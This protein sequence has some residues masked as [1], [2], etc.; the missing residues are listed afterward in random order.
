MAQGNGEFVRKNKKLKAVDGHFMILNPNDGWEYLNERNNYIDVLSFG[1][2]DKIIKGCKF[3]LC[4]TKEKSLDSPLGEIS[5]NS[6]FLESS[7]NAEH[8]ASGQLLKRIYKLSG[9]NEYKFTCPNELTIELLYS[10]YKEQVL[11]YKIIENI[12]AIK[13]STRIET[14]KRLLVAYEYIHDNIREQICIEQLSAVSSLSKFHLYDSFKKAFGKTP[15]QY[16]NRL[17]VSKA[18]EYIKK[19]SNSISEVSDLLGYNDLSVFSKVFK[20]VYGH[21]PSHYIN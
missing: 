12:D 18:K 11:G 7:L 3:Y 5:E 19:G 8:Y 13:Y 21:P 14:L 6:F 9:Q 17:K 10:L 2:T 20:R 1:I 4:A 16:I 15:H